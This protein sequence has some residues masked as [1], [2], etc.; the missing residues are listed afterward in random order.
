MAQLDRGEQP[1]NGI[2]LESQLVHGRQAMASTDALVPGVSITDEC[3]GFDETADAL[4]GLA[5]A[6][7]RARTRGVNPPTTLVP[8]SA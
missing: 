7:R 3:L 4:A 2:M 6:V 5:S 8:Q 1:P